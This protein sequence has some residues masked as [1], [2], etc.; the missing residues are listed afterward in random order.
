ME[1]LKNFFVLF[2][3]NLANELE[4]DTAK[5]LPIRKKRGC[6]CGSSKSNKEDE[7]A[8]REEMKKKLFN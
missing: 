3:T 4:N 7:E 8:K 1:N 6:G 2:L 5:K